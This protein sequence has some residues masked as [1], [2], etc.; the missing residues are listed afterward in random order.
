[1]TGN[2]RAV[3]SVHRAFD[4]IDGLRELDGAGVTEL[5]DHVDLPASTVHNYLSTLRER[6]YVVRDGDDYRL[7]SR[8]VH[9][10]DYARGR[11]ELFR[12]GKRNVRRLAEETGETA[13]LMVEEYGRGIYLMSEVGT[14]G[15]RNYAHVRRREYLHSTAAGKAILMELDADRR[16]TVLDEH[17]LP[18]VTP[19]TV[20]DRERLREELA[21]A[22][23]RGYA[24]ND[25]ENTDG[26][27]AVG[28][29]VELGDGGYGAVSLSGPVNHLPD[30]RFR[31]ELP[32]LVHDT[33]RSIEIELVN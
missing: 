10:G 7:A 18:A 33:A 23:D 19:A 12:V 2:E 14:E 5:A 28:A 1:M 8:L 31:E 3:K 22:R 32:R 29:P 4:V 20:T 17:G 11:H 30:E 26:I 16:E 9:L 13:N 6:R 24:Y 15:L 25:E 21:A 27:R